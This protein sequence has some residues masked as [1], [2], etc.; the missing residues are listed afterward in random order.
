ME[1]FLD[2]L[3]GVLAWRG[4]EIC[5]TSPRKRSSREK[6]EKRRRT[7]ESMEHAMLSPH[8]NNNKKKD[9]KENR[10]KKKNVSRSYQFVCLFLKKF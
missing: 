1:D 8:C 5:E 7:K 4:S 2:F 6:V 10:R 3:E 9:E